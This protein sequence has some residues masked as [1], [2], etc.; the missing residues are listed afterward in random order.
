MKAFVTSNGC[1]EN[2]LDAGRVRDYLELNGYDISNDLSQSDIILF[3]ACALTEFHESMS[4]NMV[5]DMH[6]TALAGAQVVV[7]GCL[8]KINPERLR[9]VHRGIA[10]GESEIEKLDELISASTPI[11]HVRSNRP[12]SRCHPNSPMRWTVLGKVSSI[13]TSRTTRKANA[14]NL[15]RPGDE[16]IYYIKTCTGCVG[17][18]T[19]CAV[20][21]SRG[22][23]RSKPVEDVMA[24]FHQGLAEGFHEF[25]LMGTDLG[26]YGIDQGC[27]LVDLLSEMVNTPGN[28]RIGLRNTEPRF[29]KGMLPQM[30]QIMST[31]KI[32]FIGIP[33]E[34][35]SDRILDLMK[36]GYTVNDVR[37]CV[38]VLRNSWPDVKLRTQ[39]M[40][41]FPSETWS[42]FMQ[43]MKI[44]KKLNFDF[45]EV[46]RY[47]PRPNT[48]AARMDN[49]VNKRVAQLRG[50]LMIGMLT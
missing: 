22:R 37:E 31:G 40:V 19:Y 48:I 23:I 10:L 21:L 38:S 32:W 7:L 15:H 35:G 17:V 44:T 34:S 3:N 5:Q 41:G 45:T 43:S 8:P 33:I 36:R 1:P 24:E 18:C 25:A 50:L 28:Y 12:I 26:P 4:C 13:L 20:R 30:S 27:T 11:C 42:D 6:Q 16:T 39:V 46:Y 14:V 29:L 2:L 49:Q 47:S 9:Q